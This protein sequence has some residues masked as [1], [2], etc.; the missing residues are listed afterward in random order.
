MSVNASR[1]LTRVLTED[2][3]VSYTMSPKWDRN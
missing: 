1:E 2:S 3:S